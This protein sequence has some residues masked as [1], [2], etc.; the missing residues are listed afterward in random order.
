MLGGRHVDSL[1]LMR[2]FVAVVDTESF[3]AAGRRL[4]KSKALV[5]KHIGELERRLGAQLL[6][7]TT[8]R[9]G[10]T[11]IGRAYCERAR[12]LLAEFDA[13][14]DAVRSNSG[15]PRGILTLTAPQVFGELEL[16]EMTAAFQRAYPMIELDILLADRIVDL[17]GEGFEVALR[18]TELNDSS[19]IARRLCDMPILA[20]ASPAYLARHGRPLR[21]EDLARH[22]CIADTNIRGRNMWRFQRGGETINIRIAPILSV[23][24]APAVRQ[25]LLA[26]L[27]I[28]LCPQFVVARDIARGQLV[29]V[30]DEKPAYPLA[31]H[32]VYPH[33]LHL[34]AKVRAFIDF[35][36]DWYTPLPPWLRETVPDAWAAGF[37]RPA[38]AD[39]LSLSSNG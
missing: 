31:V 30:F 10:V 17:I 21:P 34:S 36:I 23:N 26:G 4:G 25:A 1:G 33:R 7:R 8:R 28:G 11:E 2:T 16:L 39:G 15:K 12:D 27:G 6:H 20:C 3:T 32:L 5:S 18:I 24:S 9:V 37:S 38:H 19:L 14:E 35:A 29:E 22:S 13:M